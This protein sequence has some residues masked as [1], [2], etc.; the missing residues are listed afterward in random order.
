MGD[1]S[2]IIGERIR[3]IRK[4]KKI[5]QEE[6][7]HLASLSDTFIGQVERAEKNITVESLHKIATALEISLEDLFRVSEH[8][9]KSANTEV[10]IQII[11]KLYDR[12]IEEQ[13]DVLKIID[14]VLGL[15][16][17]Q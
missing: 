5:S 9:S 14:I 16:N 15:L 4:E 11:D 12:T 8:L 1:V 17:K 7:A 6:L 13:E 2:K 3:T 10:L